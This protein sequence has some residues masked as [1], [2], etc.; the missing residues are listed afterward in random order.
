[1]ANP[2]CKRCGG[3][4]WVYCTACDSTGYE[5]LGTEERRCC[6]FC[7]GGQIRC[8]CESPPKKDPP[9]QSDLVPPFNLPRIS[10]PVSQMGI[11]YSPRDKPAPACERKE[12]IWD[13]PSGLM[14]WAFILCVCGAVYFVWFY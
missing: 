11:E 6:R 8:Y 12:G 7:M 4:G 2:N 14:L 3:R 1:M 5:G 13:V 10:F 9:M